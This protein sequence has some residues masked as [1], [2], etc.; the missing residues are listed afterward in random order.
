MRI[1]AHIRTGRGLAEA[2]AYAA[3][4]GCETMQVFS[5]SPLQWRSP[6]H[7]EGEV[8]SFRYA[9]ARHDLALAATHAAYLI[10]VASKDDALWERSIAALADEILRAQALGAPAVVTHLGSSPDARPHACARAAEALARA[11]AQ[12]EGCAAGVY[13]ENSAGSGST[14]GATAEEILAVLFAIPTEHRSRAAICIDT[15]H[16]H[17]AGYDLSTEAGWKRLLDP[18]EREGARVALVHANDATYACGSRRDRHAWIGEGTIG[19]RGFALMFEQ[20]V[21]RA[22]DVVTEMPGETP[23]KDV[24][25][26]A[27]LKE[28]RDR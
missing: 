16:A 10:N 11:L 14:L 7:D 15:C 12:T 24:I 1:G 18:I 19:Q 3:S 28:L 2:V 25:N 22:A 17:V 4:V 26:V 20:D 27:R 6:K 5:K 21:V 9:L 13:L 8:G 23:S